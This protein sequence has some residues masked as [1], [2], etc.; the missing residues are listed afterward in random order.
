MKIKLLLT[1]LIGLGI[2]NSSQ[3]FNLNELPQDI[4]DPFTRY[5]QAEEVIDNETY[6]LEALP[7]D[8]AIVPGVEIRLAGVVKR[9]SDNEQT[10]QSSIVEQ[11]FLTYYYFNAKLE[12]LENVAQRFYV[13]LVL[14][15]V[16]NGI[17]E[18][19]KNQN[20]ILLIPGGV[21]SQIGSVSSIDVNL[22]INELKRYY[23]VDEILVNELRENHIV[24]GGSILDTDVRVPHFVENDTSISQLA[25]ELKMSIDQI[26]DINA[27]LLDETTETSELIVPKKGE[28]VLGGRG[29]VDYYPSYNQ[30]IK[31]TASRFGVEPELLIEINEGKWQFAIDEYIITLQ[32]NY[33]YSHYYSLVK[34]T[35]TLANA[36]HFANRLRRN[37]QMLAMPKN[38]NWRIGYMG[39]NQNASKYYTVEFGPFLHQQGALQM[40]DILINKIEE[41][42]VVSEFFE[43]KINSSQDFITS[44]VVLDQDGRF[45][46]ASDQ[47]AGYMGL[48]VLAVDRRSA[49][50]LVD[51]DQLS[52]S[53]DYAPTPIDE[54]E[55]SLISENVEPFQETEV[56]SEEGQ[57]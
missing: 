13:P 41:C 19:N 40:C 6:E 23:W 54:P 47:Q 36:H 7:V 20:A 15:K 8:N 57:L 37:M 11:G 24:V 29:T 3:A 46:V 5:S 49:T 38:A 26:Y 2:V 39:K 55:E 43:N 18:K 28:L 53:L 44:V 17:N 52:L 33:K 25:D 27:Y 51:G 16:I 21:F 32:N 31:N 50:I 56:N 1:T 48:Q 30:T 4:D 9:L 12:S 42:L 10:Y 45:A 14:L 22:S 34:T 35:Q